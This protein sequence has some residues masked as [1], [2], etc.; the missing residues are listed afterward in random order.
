MSGLDT[1]VRRTTILAVALLVVV[2]AALASLAAGDASASRKASESQLKAAMIYR[3]ATFVRWSDGSLPEGTFGICIIGDDSM[4]SAL[5]SITSGRKLLG[6]ELR[7]GHLPDVATAEADCALAFLGHT[8]HDAFDALLERFDA[9]VL[10]VSDMP[11]FAR[12]GG[13]IEIRSVGRKKLRFEV[14]QG[15]FERAEL[16]VSSRLLELAV[17]IHAPTKAGG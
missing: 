4:A 17:E 12:R 16:G 10:T 5:E 9:N 14:N 8:R 13:M 2:A 1:S 11:E 7:V 6:R 15:A 3:L